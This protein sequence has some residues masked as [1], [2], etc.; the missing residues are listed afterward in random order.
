[1]LVRFNTVRLGTAQ[2]WGGE[3]EGEGGRGRERE[4]ERERERDEGEKEGGRVGGK[5][6]Y[7]TVPLHLISPLYKAMR[8]P[9]I[10]HRVQ[11]DG[12]PSDPTLSV[13][14]TAHTPIAYQQLH[15][16]QHIPHTHHCMQYTHRH[17]SM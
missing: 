4:R 16:T 3:R 7:C 9:V 8:L 5:C 1:M 11:Q 13:E 14:D 15:T 2:N 6:G 10:H 12:T 17:T